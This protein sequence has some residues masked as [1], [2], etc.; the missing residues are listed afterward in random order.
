MPDL[1]TQE[2]KRIIDR[3]A[4][5]GLKATTIVGGE[6]TT[7][8]DLPELVAHLRKNN[9]LPSLISNF[10]SLD[11][12]AINDLASAGLFS[13]QASIDTLHG[14]GR[15][16]RTWLDLLEHARQVGVLPLVSTVVTSRNVDEVPQLAEE[17][18][19][20][21]IMYNCSLY[22]EVGNAF[23]VTVSGLK[24][25]KDKL[26]PTLSK[27]EAVKKRTSAIRMKYSYL[28][29]VDALY[30]AGTWHCDPSRDSWINVDAD[31]TL[32]PCQEYSSSIRVLDIPSL[33]D[34]AWRK[35][36]YDKA[37]ACR[38]CYYQCYFEQE[39]SGLPTLLE[40]LAPIL[41]GWRLLSPNPRSA[42]GRSLRPANEPLK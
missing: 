5:W 30:Y 8:K 12:A 32:M 23:S 2:W 13:L 39:T 33:R 36:K 34:K 17:V 11:A 9:I 40:E 19:E 37:A 20:R 42:F 26:L 38:G 10:V 24:A 16:N 7:R 21:G 6:P 25:P 31:G 14:V 29:H 28:K 27:V 1:P 4:S 35:L 22:Q 18:T 41:R 3:L 15:G